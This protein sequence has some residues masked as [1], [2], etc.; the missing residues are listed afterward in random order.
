ML[1]I[2]DIPRF[3]QHLLERVQW[4]TDL[5]FQTRTTID[6]LDYSG[7]GLNQGSKVVIAAA[8]PPRCSLAIE[9]RGDIPAATV[10][11]SA[12]RAAGHSGACRDRL[13]RGIKRRSSRFA[14]RLTARGDKRLPARS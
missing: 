2:H 11:R 12:G 9:L 3:F 8:G 10:P 5:H 4:R 7:H 6:T 1:E 14:G 13:P